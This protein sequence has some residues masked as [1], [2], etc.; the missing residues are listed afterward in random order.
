[1]LGGNKRILR[2][3]SSLILKPPGNKMQ[4]EVEG[5]K[6]SPKFE[7]NTYGVSGTLQLKKNKD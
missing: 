3:Y 5:Y 2:E 7:I 6:V 4:I 1:M